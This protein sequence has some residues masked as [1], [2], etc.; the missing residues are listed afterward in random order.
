M[1]STEHLVVVT[2]EV[3]DLFEEAEVLYDI[4]ISGCDDKPIR[5]IR[6]ICTLLNG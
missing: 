4:K 5:R 1:S 6:R 3:Y 2:L